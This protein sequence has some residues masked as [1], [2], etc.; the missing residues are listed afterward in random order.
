MRRPSLSM[1]QNGAPARQPHPGEPA[2]MLSRRTRR[3]TH[4][5][6][7]S[8]SR[9]LALSLSRSRSLFLSPAVQAQR[10]FFGAHT[11]ELLAEPGKFVHTNWTGS[12][13]NVSASTYN[14]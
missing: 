10:D 4:T 5:F 2:E 11:Y 12:G 3:S 1:F 8:L 6:S 14:A 7:L 13:G 9:S